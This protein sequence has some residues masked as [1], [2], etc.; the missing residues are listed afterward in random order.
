MFDALLN[1]TGVLQ[2]GSRGE[3]VKEWQTFLRS[4][5]DS[6]VVVDGSYGPQSKAATTAFQ[7]AKGLVVDGKVGR[8]SLHAALEVLGLAKTED[9]PGPGRITSEQMTMENVPVAVETAKAMFSPVVLGL[10]AVG[11]ILWLR[12]KSR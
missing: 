2:P 10:M 12:R 3:A 5:V 9:R 6:K 1:F 7:Q 4:K 8:Q 11:A